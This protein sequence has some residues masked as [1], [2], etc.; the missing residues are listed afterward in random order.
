MMVWHEWCM[1]R[2]SFSIVGFP[3]VC[4]FWVVD[5]LL[6]RSLRLEK[7][8]NI[9]TYKT[10]VNQTY[11]LYTCPTYVFLQISWCKI[12]TDPR[13]CWKKASSTR[14]RDNARFTAQKV[15]RIQK[16]GLCQIHQREGQGSWC[17]KPKTTFFKSTR[18]F[19]KLKATQCCGL[20]FET[21]RIC[22]FCSSL[23]FL[24][25]QVLHFFN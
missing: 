12:P 8:F 6:S 1:N 4:C 11:V 5:Q 2:T 21:S 14:G 9:C 24:L 13:P 10:T 20:D 15:F 22:V 18:R 7:K 17:H 3:I 19:V 16:S 23:L 25:G